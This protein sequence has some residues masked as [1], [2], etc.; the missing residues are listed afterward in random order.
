MEVI[1]MTSAPSYRIE[2]F[3]QIFVGGQYDFMPTLRQIA[4]Y[5]KETSSPAKQFFPVIPF[6]D[7]SI[8]VGETLA[9]DLMILHRC[10]AAIF[11]LSDLGAQLVEMQYAKNNGIRSLIV[12]PIRT[13]KNVPE[14]GRRTV[15]SFDMNHFGYLDFQE[16]RSVIWRFLLGGGIQRDYARR[17]VPDRE[18]DCQLRHVKAL[19]LAT[20]HTEARNLIDRLT[21]EY[22]KNVDVWLESAFATFRQG[23][24]P[25]SDANL[26]VAE[27]LATSEIDKAEIS[28]FRA[29]FAIE[30]GRLEDAL[31]LLKDADKQKP[32]DA[33]ILMVLGYVMW[34]VGSKRSDKKL[35]QNAVKITEMVVEETSRSGGSKIQVSD[36]VVAVSAINNIVAF[37]CDEY[38]IPEKRP[39][40]QKSS[41]L[42]HIRRLDE[43]SEDLESWHRAFER[44]RMGWL[45]SR[46]F[47]RLL[48]AEAIKDKQMAQEATQILYRSLL[49][50]SENLVI[51]RHYQRARTLVQELA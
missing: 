46:G 14:R 45:D 11:D 38:D 12:Y 13:R 19:E 47:A 3:G 6:D 26:E 49:G 28:Y 7:P 41:V 37:R 20:N 44:T 18:L 16:L 30:E 43:L 4:E 32:D 39:D 21:K 25:E 34:I 9:Q 5:V 29:I 24:K 36:P 40:G 8:S 48:L 31:N 27:S 42:D 22:P 51:R 23:E 17:D 1:E 35:K 10:E 33:R 2:T 50:D 15:L